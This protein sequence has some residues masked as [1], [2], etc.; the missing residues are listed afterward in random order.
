MLVPTIP[1]EDVFA[2]FTIK[3][4]INRIPTTIPI[5]TSTRYSTAVNC[6]LFLYLDYTKHELLDLLLQTLH[7]ELDLI[8]K[9]FHFRTSKIIV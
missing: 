5:S 4:I 2:A 1:W 6:I 8:I 3:I 9:N 7:L